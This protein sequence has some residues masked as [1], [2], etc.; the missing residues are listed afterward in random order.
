METKYARAV[1]W[2]MWRDFGRLRFFK[3]QILFPCFSVCCHENNH[4]I[5]CPRLNENLL[6]EHATILFNQFHLTSHFTQYF[7]EVLSIPIHADAQLK[8]LLMWE[9]DKI[10][11]NSWKGVAFI[12]QHFSSWREVWGSYTFRSLFLGLVCSHHLP[13]M[14]LKYL[15][16]AH[17]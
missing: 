8:K 2:T 17:L 7:Q 1:Y 11:S 15:L 14:F 5:T 4:K 13:A 6:A 10:R 9:V 16:G 12:T 3:L